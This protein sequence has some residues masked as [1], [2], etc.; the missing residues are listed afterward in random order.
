MNIQTREV[1]ITIIAMNFEQ[2]STAVQL[3]TSLLI[4][5]VLIDIE[6]C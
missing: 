5:A 2:N 6:Q 3:R 1:G 4:G